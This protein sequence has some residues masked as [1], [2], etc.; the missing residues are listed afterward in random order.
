MI[1]PIQFANHSIHN[2]GFAL[3]VTLSLMILLTIMAVGLLS[4]SAVSLRGSALDAAQAEARANARMAL[5]IA[6]SDIQRAAGSDQRVTATANIAATANGESLPAGQP[7]LNDV[8]PDKTLKGLS[9]VQAGTRYWTGVFSNRDTPDMIHSKTPSP[10]IERWLVSGVNDPN[11]AGLSITPALAFCATNAEG[12]VA[13]PSK[14]VVLVGTHSAGTGPG[15]EDRYVAAPQVAIVPGAGSGMPGRFAY[16]VGDEGVK[17]RINIE[18][19]S[20]EA[21][22]YSSLI[23]QRRGWET[24]G[25][26]ADYPPADGGADSQLPRLITFGTSQVAIPALRSGNPSPMQ[27]AFHSATADSRGL[28]V[29]T[30]AGGT[31]VDLTAAFSGGLP[32][33]A[34]ADGYDNYPVA[35]G[36]VISEIAH[37]ALDNL[38]WDHIGE[39]H[40]M[41]EKLTDG[42]L[43]VSQ[44]S[45]P[46]TAPIAPIIT[47]FRILMGV[48]PEA[49]GT[50]RSP[51]G[52]YKFH[53]CGKIAVTI[54]N[55]YSVPLKWDNDL[56]FEI[57]NQTPPGNSPSRI[58]QFN[59]THAFIPKDGT[60]DRPGSEP[61]V[62]NQT[63]FRISR[64]Q[65]APGE[66]RAYTQAT[67]VT[68]SRA[69]ANQ[70]IN[71][72]MAP[73]ASASPFD[74]N[75]CVE[76]TVDNESTPRALDVRESWQTTL[77]ML[78][79]RLAGARDWLRRIERFELDNGY[80]VPNT[81]KFN[82]DN[83]K[84]VRGPVP[85]MLYSFQLSQPGMDYLS[86]MP[87]GYE[88][89]QRASTLRTYADFN[90]RA[91]N[92]T[93]PIASYN[94]PPFFM[95]S[96]NSEAQL[97]TLEPGG[98]TGIGFTRNLAITP[99]HW[100]HT[101]ES[102]SKR[103]VLFSFP[104]QF[105]SLAQLQHADLTND[106]VGIS[107]S[108]Q[109][110][111]AFANSYASVFVRRDLTSQPRVDYEIIGDSD[112][113][114][115]RRMPRTY[116]DIS[117]ILNNALWD[118]YFFSNTP[119][120]GGPPEHPALI[121][122]PGAD[123]S[124]LGDPDKAAASLMIE[125]S[126]NINST[127][128]NAW[129]ALL[130]SSRY[131]KH[132]ADTGPASEAAFPR[133]LE[134][135]ELHAIPPTGEDNDSF[136]GYRRLTNDELDELATQIVKQ[137]RRRGPFVSLSHFVNRAL[138][139]I[140]TE[141]EL[142]RCGALQLALD[143]SGINISLDGR[144]N[145]FRGISPQQDR[146]VLAEKQGAPRADMDGDD[147]GNRPSDA[148]SQAPDW[149][150]TSRD[151]NFGAVASIVAD[152]LTLA[153]GTGRGRGAAMEREQGY[154]STGIPGWVTQAD[155]LQVIGPALSARSDTFR[156]RSSGQAL[157]AAGNV[158]AT[159]Y[160]EAIIQR[161][162]EF[163][164]PANQPHDRT[165]ALT[166]TNRTY[167]R[168]FEI[169]SFRWLSAN[170]I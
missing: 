124:T 163:V 81:R 17:A 55:P 155:V 4:L 9:A 114:G 88:L 130:A 111:N 82:N 29:D 123:S 36:R 7:P 110:G 76:M 39:F 97:G 31:R 121:T 61:A 100:G 169:I 134:Q 86:L 117:Y 138:A 25:G 79:M 24:V 89:G 136:S 101:S 71:V 18:R 103:T 37:P 120:G 96:N 106:E 28:L 10:Q 69:S 161:Q 35:G 125:G 57:K 48:R 46:K 98:Q 152:R 60:V 107:I 154:R 158:I 59:S 128:K 85:L 122:V 118:R 65:L 142:T 129:K 93:K 90:L 62:F 109:P 144:R 147:S 137:V 108:H 149:A 151:N 44:R 13:D 150:F 52:N 21:G 145:G 30:L 68:R 77:V 12:K 14:A 112:K 33:R 132:P 164:D 5:M 27:T 135:P 67:K 80:F 105:T 159:A 84:R 40:G 168:K 49:T 94:P 73:F 58:W 41:S 99:L 23:A 2:R 42:T 143:E 167:G 116:Y 72:P 95:E 70:R 113:S 87:P 162:I 43:N 146:V 83:T 1:S 166:A 119:T 141:P 50:P 104:R 16:W 45:G 3:V 165:D 133:S 11:S 53:P 148:D 47:D 74:F 115:A 6:I 32:R 160:C 15:S 38:T 54:A 126:F 140:A 92:F 63:V 156:I 56:E 139:P 22:S 66:A 170:E 26:F 8:A 157:D 131:F 20:E 34:P 19:S 64:G 91:A 78:E 127:D 153:G 51:S 75:L 102:G